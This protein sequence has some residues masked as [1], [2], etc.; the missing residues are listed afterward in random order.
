MYIDRLEDLG[1]PTTSTPASGSHVILP[2]EDN[3]FQIA[4]NEI[5]RRQCDVDSLTDIVFF[6]LHPDLKGTRLDPSKPEHES[7]IKQWSRIRSKVKRALSLVPT[8]KIFDRIDTNLKM[9]TS[10]LRGLD[11]HQLLD[12]AAQ[13]N[14]F[15]K[16]NQAK[17]RCVTVPF[18]KDFQ[19]FCREMELRVGRWTTRND[20]KARSRG[21]KLVEPWVEKLKEI[22]QTFAH[23]GTTSGSLIGFPI[24]FNYAVSK[25]KKR[26][27]GIYLWG[28]EEWSATNMPNICS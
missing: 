8:L 14:I 26:L 4:L 12:G 27:C 17:L 28:L 18:K 1:Q 22:H 25:S 3:E 10:S 19:E 24:D 13:A 23:K 9:P 16:S 20:E 21:R 7:L 15:C 11:S 5:R 6:T 2:G